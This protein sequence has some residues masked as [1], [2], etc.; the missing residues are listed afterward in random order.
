MQQHIDELKSSSLMDAIIS[1]LELEAF[2]YNGSWKNMEEATD[3]DVCIFLYCD[4]EEIPPRGV[5]PSLSKCYSPTCE[6]P[7]F[8][9]SPTC[10][11]RS[12]VS[13]TDLRTRE[14]L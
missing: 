4:G 7:G 12:R 2:F 3:D 14:W 8:C 10:P 5:F 9:Y 11:N 13:R 6:E 1:S